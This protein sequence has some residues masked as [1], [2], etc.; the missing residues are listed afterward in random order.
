MVCYKVLKVTKLQC[1]RFS[2]NE[3]CSLLTFGI[4]LCL[5][6]VVTYA[7]KPKFT[8]DITLTAVNKYLK[9]FNLNISTHSTTGS[10]DITAC[11]RLKCSVL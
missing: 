8:T 7:L 10:L 4:Q 11:I 1:F 6:N 3:A 5:K 9:C 2:Y